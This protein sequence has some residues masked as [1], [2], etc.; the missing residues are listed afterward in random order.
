MESRITII[1]LGVS[2]FD[3]SVR[4][5]R[6]GLGWPMSSHS[7]PQNKWAL[8]KSFGTRLSLFP[9]EELA[10]DM[11]PGM[12]AAGSGF[13]G[14]TLAHNVREKS[15]VQ[16]VLAAA[17]AAGGRIVKPAQDAFWGGYSGY[18][19]DPD[20]YHWEVAWSSSFK[21]D[22]HGNLMLADE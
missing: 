18:F 20:G 16:E 6:D 10:K 17:E 2:D 4:F 7:Q 8:F 12:D 11:S 13:T 9:R 1:T 21:F 3:R 14:I 19:A 15:Q 5:Y 22:A